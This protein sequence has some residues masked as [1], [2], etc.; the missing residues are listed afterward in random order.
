MTVS[1]QRDNPELRGNPQWKLVRIATNQGGTP[2]LS[3][4]RTRTHDLLIT[5]GPTGDPGS[6]KKNK[7]SQPGLIAANSHLAQEIG[8]AVSNAIAAR[9]ATQP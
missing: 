5:F 7:G 6:G 4:N 1:Q 3:A 2:L 9:A 8:L